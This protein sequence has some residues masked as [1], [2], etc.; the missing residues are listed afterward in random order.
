MSLDP[1]TMLDAGAVFGERYRIVR[2]IRTG[3]MGAV[4]EAVHGETGRRVALKVMLPSL[5][6]DPGLRARFKLEATVAASV[7]SEHIVDVFDAGIDAVSGAPFLVMELLRGE[8][9]STLLKRQGPF[10]P[11]ESVQLLWQA[12]LALEKTHAN[13]IVH[14]DLKPDNLFLTER[15][16]G[17]PRLK[18]LDFGI[19]KVMANNPVGGQQTATVG[20]PM[21]MAPEQI[22]GDPIGP[23]SDL[24]SLG[25]IGYSLLV[26]RSYWSDDWQG[27]P[28]YPLLLKVL[29][30]AN[31][32]ATVR[33]SKQGI[34]LPM[35][36][37]RWF[38]RSTAL[39]PTQRF[40]GAFEMV[41]AL[42]EALSVGAPTQR[43]QRKTADSGSDLASGSPLATSENRRVSV[44]PRT[45]DGPMAMQDALGSE[46]APAH[47]SSVPSAPSNPSAAPLAPVSTSEAHGLFLATPQ[48]PV[49]SRR[50]GPGTPTPPSHP[51]WPQVVS[52]VPA[53]PSSPLAV[54]TPPSGV[55]LSVPTPSSANLNPGPLVPTDQGPVSS[56]SRHLLVAAMVLAG[57][58]VMAVLVIGLTRDAPVLSARPTSSGARDEATADP[59][60]P[61]AGTPATSGDAAEVAKDSTKVPA[62]ASA[63][64]HPPVPSVPSSSPKW[65]SKRFST[66]DPVGTSFY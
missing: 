14:R 1:T 11:E 4:Y 31:E 33:A 63:S 40:R 62:S 60:D 38:T 56:P 65:N 66:P 52:A 44:A 29:K 27:G 55:N 46:R 9:V 3:G 37:D 7:E 57:V 13:G 35:P 64:G 51:S 45:L 20:T 5:V 12:A 41:E 39:S 24:Y 28:I 17:S 30:G 26:G 50:S 15:D 54:P 23:A 8:D 53:S 61:V 36:F 10:G 22:N 6:A 48:G 43:R 47:V 25:H 2:C 16:D 59:V 19:A 18:I 58:A 42:A 34:T 21:Y 49:P 32:P